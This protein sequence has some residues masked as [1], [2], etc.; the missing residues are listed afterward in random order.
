MLL[1]IPVNCPR[2]GE[3]LYKVHRS[4]AVVGVGSEGREDEPVCRCEGLRFISLLKAAEKVVTLK[5]AEQKYHSPKEYG[6]KIEDVTGRHAPSEK[7]LSD[8]FGQ[9]PT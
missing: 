4:I 8:D 6:Q 3:Y 5:E 2:C 9:D 1:E 7:A